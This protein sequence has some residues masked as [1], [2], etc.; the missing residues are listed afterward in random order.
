M[1][2]AALP[3]EFTHIIIF[4][5][6]EDTLTFYA[7]IK[8]PGVYRS[9]YSAGI[10]SSTVVALAYCHRRKWECP[11]LGLG[12]LGF[13]FFVLSFKCDLSSVINVE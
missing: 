7:E 11:R 1:T 2:P 12:W 10:A 8:E 3:P 4:L 9:G 6:R 13:H 5:S